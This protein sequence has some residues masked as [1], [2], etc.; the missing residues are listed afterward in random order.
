MKNIL[1]TGGADYIGSGL[2]REL[3]AKRLQCNIY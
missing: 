3:F 2:L 1:V